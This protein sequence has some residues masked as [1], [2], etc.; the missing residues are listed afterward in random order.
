MRALRE[1]SL[2]PL[3]RELRRPG[4]RVLFVDDRSAA[5]EW[6]SAALFDA[7]WVE[8]EAPPG[9]DVRAL[10]AK[11]AGALRSGGRLICVVPNV[12]SLGSLSRRALLGDGRSA[13]PRRV[14]ESWREAFRPYV[15]WRRSRGFGVLLP[16][17]PG[18][19]QSYPL[20]FA[21]LGAADHVV[22]KWPAFRALGA[23]AIHEGVRR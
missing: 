7:A 21:L 14:F 9:F 19:A 6:G 3:R 17:A 2:E 23:V 10:A 18:W 16:P 22:G 12:E 20:A 1:Y 13:V 5:E 8:L 4:W 11:V 15:E